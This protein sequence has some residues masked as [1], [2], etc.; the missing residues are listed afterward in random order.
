VRRGEK[1]KAI[2]DAW[3]TPTYAPHLA[4]RLREL[5]VKDIPGVFHVVSGGEGTTYEE[6]AWTAFEQVGCPTSS[7]ES[8][9]FDS[10]KR[11]APRPRNSKLRCLL[12]PALGF[13]PLPRWEK[14]L[15]DFLQSLD[16]NV[17]G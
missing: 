1:V 9:R 2:G 7:I 15:K 11:P 8:V 12:S 17:A 14:G 3:G 4:K 6:F 16:Q 13:A 5:V 10:L